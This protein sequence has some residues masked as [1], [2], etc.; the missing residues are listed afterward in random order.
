MYTRH[1]L[2]LN[3]HFKI[4]VCGLL[5]NEFDLQKNSITKN[6][7][8]LAM[9]SDVTNNFYGIRYASFPSSMFYFNVKK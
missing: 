4:R 7:L 2:F 5:T 1:F 8:T 9:N 6:N 3:L